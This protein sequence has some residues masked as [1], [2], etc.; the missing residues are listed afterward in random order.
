MH[1]VHTGATRY[2][3]ALKLNIKWG[4]Q[5]KNVNNLKKPKVPDFLPSHKVIK[6][7]ASLIIS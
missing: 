1:V 4:F 2:L 3:E 7:I 5:T 6:T